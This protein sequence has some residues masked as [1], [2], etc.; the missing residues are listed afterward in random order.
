[1][2]IS[3]KKY[4]TNLREKHGLTWVCGNRVLNAILWCEMFALYGWNF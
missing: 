1:M 2:W 3:L 4:L